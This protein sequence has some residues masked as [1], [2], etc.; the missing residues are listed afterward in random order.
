MKVLLTGA[1]GFLG[2]HI[3][4]KLIEKGHEVLAIK[5]T[6]S[7]LSNCENFINKVNWIDCNV[8]KWIEKCITWKPQAIIHS[9]WAG[10]DAQH[11]DDWSTQYSNINILT[12]LLYIASNSSALKFICLGSQAEYGEFNG[13]ITEEYPLNPIQKYG[14][15]KVASLH[16]V[17]EYCQLYNIDWYWVR[18]FATFGEREADN[19]L[20]PSLIKK[21]LHKESEMNFTRCDQE[22]AYLYVGDLAEAYVSILDVKG[23]SG[24][25]NLS[26]KRALPLK[27]VITYIKDKID[28]NFKLNFGVLPYRKGQAMKIQASCEK[29]IQAFGEYEKHTFEDAINQ[30]I[31]N[32]IKYQHQ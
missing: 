23:K 24:I 8:D 29:F 15:I 30:I 4:E 1:N 20:I 7:K 5:R 31:D 25:Y 17:Q 19:W 18:I 21:I 2:S 14:I 11:R 3:A 9:A 32:K 16:Q 26:S 27:Y 10:V 12:D 6:T 13:P 22:Y 28:P